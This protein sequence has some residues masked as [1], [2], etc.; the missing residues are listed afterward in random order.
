MVAAATASEFPLTCKLE[1][2]MAMGCRKI[3]SFVRPSVY[4]FLTWFSKPVTEE[5]WQHGEAVKQRHGLSSPSRINWL[6]AEARAVAA[7]AISADSPAGGVGAKAAQNY[8]ASHHF[9]TS[10][11]GTSIYKPTGITTS[12][13]PSKKTLAEKTSIKTALLRGKPLAFI[14][15]PLKGAVFYRHIHLRHIQNGLG[16]TE[17]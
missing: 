1:L 11:A 16:W 14:W 8:L 4:P 15:K 5:D 12:R 17:K 6:V 2:A 9:P 10:T 13:V 3:S 7:A